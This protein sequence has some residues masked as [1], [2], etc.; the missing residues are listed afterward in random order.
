MSEPIQI[1]EV[2]C[3]S[4]GAPIR[5]PDDVDRLNCTHCGTG[6][7]IQRGEGYISTKIAQE[8]KEAIQDTREE[9]RA[10]IYRLELQQQLST[11][12]LQLADVQSEIRS[13]QRVRKTPQVNQ[14]IQELRRQE[15]H[16]IR[17]VE[18]LHRVLEGEIGEDGLPI[19]EETQ[20][21][22]IL[23]ESYGTKNWTTSFVLCLLLGFWGVH[24]FYS[25]H[26]V[27]GLIQFLTMG[28]FGVWWLIDLYLIGTGRFR[29]ADGFLLA[30]PKTSF[31]RSCAAS[32]IVFFAISFSCAVLSPPIET[33]LLGLVNDPDRF[34]P[35]AVAGFIAALIIG[36]GLFI[37]MYVPAARIW[38]RDS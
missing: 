16:L 13:L 20:Y 6:L 23:S 32:V 1:F 9:T 14:Q 36:I 12:Q 22:E 7:I 28:G 18:Y 8:L 27:I 38:Q 35:L 17:R 15:I 31:G 3:A 24:R 11:T 37:Y 25:G 34:G 5:V 29:D 19:E 26:I 33:R 10:S 30:D 4:C 21:Q 2:S